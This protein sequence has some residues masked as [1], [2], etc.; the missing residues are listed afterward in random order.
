MRKIF[1][2]ASACHWP[3]IPK[4]LMVVLCIGMAFVLANCDQN[5]FE[6]ASDDDSYEARLEKG[7]MA[8]D[9]ED[10]AKAIKLFEQLRSDYK[11]KTEV[12]EY[13]SSAYAGFIGLD[14]FNFLKTIDELEENDDAGNIEM[15]G[16]VLGG[17]SGDLTSQE[18]VV[19]RQY[20]IAAIQAF[21][22]CIPVRD[23][24]QKVQLGLMAI[25][26][27]VLIVAEIIIDDLDLDNIVLTEAGLEDLYSSTAPDFDNVA[28]IDAYLSD[29]NLDL[30]LVLE[31]VEALDA[32]SEENDL[33][34]SF[35]EFLLDMG[36]GGED[37]PVTQADLEAYINQLQ[38]E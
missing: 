34:E 23:D 22:E 38:S 5:F 16:Y 6:S 8:L 37:D 24:D 28:A 26:D 13:L 31:S 12:C 18:V 1:N 17:A 9:D 33:S 7:V 11:G 30:A 10:Y 21:I 25:F 3:R 27:A 14:T 2:A 4:A 29:L 35:A 20:L 19:K 32:I 36:Y 15:V